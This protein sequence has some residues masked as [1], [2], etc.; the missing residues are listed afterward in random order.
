[1]KHLLLLFISS[2]ILACNSNPVS[3]PGIAQGYLKGHVQLISKEGIYLSDNS[4][5]IITTDPFAQPS[6]SDTDGTWQ[7]GPIPAT[8]YSVAFSKDG[9]FTLR[10]YHLRVDSSDTLL[11]FPPI[12]LGQITDVAVSRLTVTSRSSLPSIHIDG[13]LTRASTTGSSV[14]ILI[15]KSAPS[16]LATFSFLYP[17]QLHVPQQSSTFAV[18]TS[19][20]T[21]TIYKRGDTLCAIACVGPNGSTS[22]ASF[23]NANLMYD[24][25]TPRVQ[26]SN[27]V[28]FV[29]P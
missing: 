10:R 22:F 15:M 29:N 7:L 9:W 18:D 2:L 19:L 11:V 6:V 1:M 12:V 23:N 3:G 13:T 4:G 24:F 16:D 28:S 20:P 8:D 21:S 17:I 5:V 26:F 27:A 14:E 25:E